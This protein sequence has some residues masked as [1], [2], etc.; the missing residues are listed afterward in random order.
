ME[1]EQIIARLLPVIKAEMKADQEKT[2]AKVDA[3]PE[4]TTYCRIATE[5]CLGKTEVRIESVQDTHNII[6]ELL[7]VVFSERSVSRLYNENQL[8]LPVS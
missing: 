3:W 7:F 8:P 2:L 1:M 6:E 4:G 5:A